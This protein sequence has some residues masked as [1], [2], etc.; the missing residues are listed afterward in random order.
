ML[1]LY[2]LKIRK[3]FPFGIELTGSFG[4]LAQS[5][6]YTIGADVRWSL[7]EGFRTGQHPAGFFFKDYTPARW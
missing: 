1:Q 2:Q 4:Y 6:L 7:F 3:G 5:S